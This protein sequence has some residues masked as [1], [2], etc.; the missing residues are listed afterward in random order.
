[1]SNMLEDHDA[2]ALRARALVERMEAPP[3]TS[4]RA[5]QPELRHPNPIVGELVRVETGYTSFGR[6]QI[7][8]L[9]DLDG[10]GWSIWLLHSV[11]QEEFARKRPAIGD[12]VA[13]Q[14]CGKVTPQGGGA[15]YGKFKLM[16]DRPDAAIDWGPVE[17]QED[18]PVAPAPEVDDIPF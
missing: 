3:A 11:L 16:V 13:V 10:R 17:S 12:L 6:K 5:D 2:V 9:R 14:Y 8:V 4:W 1:M 18:P 15:P 7:V